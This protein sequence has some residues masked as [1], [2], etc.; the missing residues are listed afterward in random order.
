LPDPTPARIA[1]LA[2]E[3]LSTLP[4]GE[5]DL[6]LVAKAAADL[7]ELERRW[8]ALAVGEELVVDW[9]AYRRLA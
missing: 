9:P 3:A 4:D 2:R 6:E 7:H 1:T 8:A 5:V